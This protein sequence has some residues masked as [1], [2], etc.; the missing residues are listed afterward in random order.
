M[1]DPAASRTV[2][3]KVSGALLDASG[4]DT[5][6]DALATL[7]PGRQAVL[8]HGGGPQL[9]EALAKLD[10]PVRRHRGLRITSRA[11]AGIVQATLDAVGSQLTA[12]LGDRGVPAEHVDSLQH[13]LTA[14]TKRLDDEVD[15]GRVGTPV[16]F[17]TD[18]LPPPP[19]VPVVTPVGTD[20]TG[21]LNVNADEAAAA[22]AA[23]TGSQALVF[24]A[25]VPGVLDASGSPLPAIDADEARRLIEEEI[26]SGGMQ[27]KLEAGLEAID[28]GVGTVRVAPLD[29]TL[30]AGASCQDPTEAPGT[31]ITP[32]PGGPA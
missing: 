6:A 31:E 8:V 28:A 9:D 15:L 22:V 13:R 32:Q 3:L 26:A 4:T 25:R 12:R 19:S 2:T 1:P 10:E 29:E 21:P 7:L 30:L 27:P 5:L 23:A 24:A 18:G 11:Q 16:R 20:G 14:K 17:R